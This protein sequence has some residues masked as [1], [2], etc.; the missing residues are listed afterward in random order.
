M[1]ITYMLQV[2]ICLSFFY[3]LYHVAL[4][5][6]TLFQ[7]NRIYLLLSVV[8]SIILPLIR[9]YIL[10][11][12]NA[13]S[14]VTAPYIYVGSYLN[15]MNEAIITPREQAIP[16]LSILMSLY[17]SGVLYLSYR[18]IV[19][20]VAILKMKRN[21]EKKWLYDQLCV[22]S[23]EVKSPFSF[24][25]TV[26][27]PLSHQFNE[28]EMKEIISH[29]KTHVLGFHTFDVLFMEL[30]CIGL[31][32]SPMV[33]MYRKKLRE[34]H[35]FLADAEVVKD[36]P[37]ENYASFLV[38]Q[39]NEGLQHRLSNQLIYSQLKNRLI[40]MNKERSFQ[41]AK[42]KYFGIIPILLMALV[43][44]SF[45]E[46][47][48]QDIN[49]I[50]PGHHVYDLY[51]NGLGIYTP[52]DSTLSDDIR[53]LH[54]TSILVITQNKRI[55]LDQKEIKYEFLEEALTIAAK[56]SP[57]RYIYLQMD[58]HLAV[59]DLSN[60]LELG[61]KLNIHFILPEKNNDKVIYDMKGSLRETVI[62]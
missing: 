18:I 32:P 59:A 58:K 16:W 60:V 20:V 15:T 43:I 49:K 22:L 55:L 12:Q 61:N 25:Y 6:E 26:Y 1:L 39:K 10:E 37:W 41:S 35:E 54:D 31:W 7:T 50:A 9:I 29:E 36:T 52:L 57:G 33:Y 28:D 24:F 13:H 2:T 46:K 3:A 53:V 47:A 62:T 48:I 56:K 23:P 30:V 44:F 17:V 19:S 51:A 14:I 45:R 11:Q 34:V 40:M 27:L 42:Y 4:Q 38:S 8:M 5:K 21:G